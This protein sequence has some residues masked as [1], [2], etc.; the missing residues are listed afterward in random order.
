MKDSVSKIIVVQLIPSLKR[1]RS[2]NL[3]LLVTFWNSNSKQSWWV[4][5]SL[6]NFVNPS[7]FDDLSIFQPWFGFRNIG[8][9][10]H[11]ASTACRKYYARG[12][13]ESDCNEEL[14]E[15]SRP[16]LLRRIKKQVLTVTCP[17][18]RRWL[19]MQA[20]LSFKMD[21]PRWLNRVYWGI[22]YWIRVHIEA[23][24]HAKPNK[25]AD[26]SS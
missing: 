18:R 23:A 10:T 13:S 12:T 8:E 14:H 1:I 11:G 16:F 2:A 19:S 6:L 4:V 15:I 21:I 3:L 7:I 17:R 25:Q 20:C 5:E 24:S 22:F 26:E 9:K